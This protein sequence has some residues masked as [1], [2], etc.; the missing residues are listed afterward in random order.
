M[1]N[2]VFYLGLGILFTHEMDAMPNH[3]WRVLPVLRSLSD[4]TGELAFLLAHIPVF[5]LTIA[6]IASL[7]PGTRLL[8]QQIASGFLILH[9]VLHFAFSGHANYEFSSPV[10]GALILGAALCGAAYFSL[11]LQ[12]TTGDKT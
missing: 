3:E 5:A 10:S 1:K 2:F 11:Q 9:A 4:M 12:L 6:F 8:A 7:T